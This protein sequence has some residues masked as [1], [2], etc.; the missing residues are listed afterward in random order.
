MYISL[1]GNLI[2]YKKEPMTKMGNLVMTKI[3]WNSVLS[4]PDAKYMN[5]NVKNVYFNVSF[6]VYFIDIIPE[7]FYRKIKFEQQRHILVIYGNQKRNL[8]LTA[9]GNFIQ[10]NA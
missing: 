4:R 6:W 5:V 8:W 10:Q 7:H 1:G 9:D 3:L 2:H